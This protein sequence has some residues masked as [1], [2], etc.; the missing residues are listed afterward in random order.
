MD[1]ERN[2]QAAAS[3]RKALQ[4]RAV[5]DRPLTVFGSYDAFSTLCVESAGSDALYLGG[6][7]LT[8]S[9]LGLPDMGLLSFTELEDAVR[10]LRRI[11][12]LPLIV[13]FDTGYGTALQITQ[14][15]PRL[16]A[17]GADAVHIED[18]ALSKRCGH[19]GAKG[20]VE[21]SE[22]CAR[23]SAARDSAPDGFIVIARC[24]ARSVEGLESAIERAHEYSAAGADWI[25]VEA[26]ESVDELRAVGASNIGK[27]LMANM[28]IGGKT[29]L[30]SP[31]DLGNLGYSVVLYAGAALQAA[32]HAVIRTLKAV[33][34]GDDVTGDV[35]SLRERFDLLGVDAYMNLEARLLDG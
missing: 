35:L 11:S 16:A 33:R 21:P 17:A 18:Q 32:G 19:L 12:D 28:V 10:R 23:V 4:E 34:A 31:E 9:L 15:L 8:A 6:G 20:V 22:M 14:F 26:L 24:D 1:V 30:L 5:V 29:P 27:P 7:N 25:F 2:G 3:R 13:D